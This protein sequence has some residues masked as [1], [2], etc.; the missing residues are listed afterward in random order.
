MALSL[1][2]FAGGVA[3]GSAMGDDERSITEVSDK[4]PERGRRARHPAPGH[5]PWEDWR[6]DLHAVFAVGAGMKVSIT[7]G[8]AGTSNCT[9]DETYETFTT[10]K[11]EETRTI[12]MTVRNSGSC[13]FERAWSQ[14]GIKVVDPSKGDKEVG[15]GRTEISAD[16]P[17]VLRCQGIPPRF[18]WKGLSCSGNDYG[19]S[20]IRS[21]RS[22]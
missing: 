17:V 10:S 14:F 12:G 1:A 5:L 9:K 16:S 15:S 11:D 13:Y 20:P 6:A 22:G 19:R 4:L 7:G 18:E 21:A 8:G 3:L 2:S